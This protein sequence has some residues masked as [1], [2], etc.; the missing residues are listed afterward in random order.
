MQ[1][2]S[3]GEMVFFR[4]LYSPD[5]Y[6]RWNPGAFYDGLAEANQGATVM[7]GAMR[8]IAKILLSGLYTTEAWVVHP[9]A[10]GPAGRGQLKGNA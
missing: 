4:S 2:V 10:A 8:V 1:A 7:R 6:A 5:Y 3:F 9:L